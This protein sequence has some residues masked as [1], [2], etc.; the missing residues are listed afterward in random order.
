MKYLKDFTVVEAKR[1]DC[2][3]IDLKLRP[4]DG[5]L[6]E[7]YPGQFVNIQTGGGVML[8]RPISVND[9]DYEEG[10]LRLLVKNLG[11]G[12]NYL[13]H[14]DKGAKLNILLPLG[15]GFDFGNAKSI[16]LAGGGVGIAPMLYAGRKL[17]EK[18]L[19]P[20][21]LLAAKTSDELVQLSEFEK[22]G[23]VE[24]AT[25]DGTLG[26][27]GFAA[28]HPVLETKK[29]DLVCVCGP[30]PMMRSIAGVCHRN[31]FE[32]EVSLENK[33][34]CGLGACLC[35]VEDTKEGNRCTCTDGPV[36]NI[37]ELKW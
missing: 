30:M 10:I 23:I 12:S 29:W 11:R 22:Y 18:C 26:F 35:C 6:P 27:K 20:T 21:F 32:C 2:G 25:D 37:N 4:D 33:M 7:I 3:Y 5:E 9:V 28:S 34:A 13:Y 36:F 15:N 14:L 31:N 1:F 17:K 16:L 8:R 19:S 24:I